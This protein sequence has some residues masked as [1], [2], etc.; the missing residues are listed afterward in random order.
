MQ[1]NKV[2]FANKVFQTGL[3]CA[4]VAAKFWFVDDVIN[5]K[6]AFERS[7]K[8]NEVRTDVT[9]AD[10]SNRL[11]RQQTTLKGKIPINENQV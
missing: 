1:R 3:R 11:S 2:R 4:I 9:T 10:N 7:Q 5:Q 8:S 6:F